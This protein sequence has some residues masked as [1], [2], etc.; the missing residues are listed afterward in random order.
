MSQYN[1]PTVANVA[2][3]T[4]NQEYTYTI[5]ANTRKINVSS[6]LQGTLRIGFVEGC[7]ADG[8]T[9]K[10]IPAGSGGLW[11]DAMY[12]KEQTLYVASDTASDVLEI[13]AL[14]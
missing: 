8:Q 9:Y 3:T 10:S 1:K 14:D 13:L 4:A 7:T 11:I 6:R 12:L 2:L 5:P